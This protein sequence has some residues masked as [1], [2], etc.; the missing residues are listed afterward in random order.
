MTAR[1]NGILAALVAAAS[2][3][4]PSHAGL[5]DRFEARQHASRHDRDDR[6]PEP[7]DN[8]EGRPSTT[9]HSTLEQEDVTNPFV[10][11]VNLGLLITMPIW[12]P[13][14]TLGWDETPPGF[15]GAP[16]RD[17]NP[18][19]NGSFTA[20]ASFHRVSSAISGRRLSG[21]FRFDR[22]GADFSWEEFIENHRGVPDDA[23]RTSAGHLACD[24]ATD[25]EWVFSTGLGFRTLSGDE[26]H[27]HPDFIYRI[28]Y[29]PG[30]PFAFQAGFQA[31]PFGDEWL[32]ELNAGGSVFFGPVAVGA[33]YRSLMMGSGSLDGFEVGATLRF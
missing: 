25:S 23:L 20:D 11:L 16:Y 28:E 12:G 7:P 30:K 31:S 21:A 8:P 19:K 29:F 26:K 33:G 10:D 17:R 27:A 13:A 1:A 22:L 15:P 4:A 32:T 14:A 9:S 18:G 3:L 24:F 6:I 5:L 2:L